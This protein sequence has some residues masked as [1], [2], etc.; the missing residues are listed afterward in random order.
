M[1]DTHNPEEEQRGEAVEQEREQ[2]WDRLMSLAIDE[3]K[4]WEQREWRAEERLAEERE[5]RES[6]S[7]LEESGSSRG[8]IDTSARNTYVE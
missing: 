8:V 5:K 3:M 6:S 7:Q 1:S 2:L 4:P